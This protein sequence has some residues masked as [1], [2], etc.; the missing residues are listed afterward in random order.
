MNNNFYTLL[1][2]YIND[3]THFIF[4]KPTHPHLESYIQNNKSLN[5]TF[6]DLNFDSASDIIIFTDLLKQFEKSVLYIANPTFPTHCKWNLSSLTQMSND[7]P[8]TTFIIDEQFMIDN[9][10]TNVVASNIIVIPSK[11]INNIDLSTKFNEAVSLLSSYNIVVCNKSFSPTILVSLGNKYQWLLSS[12]IPHMPTL[13]GIPLNDVQSFIDYIIPL[14]THV[15]LYPPI[16]LHYINKVHQYHVMTILK[17]T[18]EILNR[19]NFPYWAESGTL[20]G[21]ARNN[22]II[23]WDD[24][25]DLSILDSDVS[26]LLSLQSEFNNNNLRIVPNRINTY[27]KVYYNFQCDSLQ[28]FYSSDAYHA[29]HID[30]FNNIYDGKLLKYYDTRFHVNPVFSEVNKLSGTVSMYCT[31]DDVF[32][33]QKSTINGLSI[34]IPSHT[35]NILKNNVGNNYKTNII[36]R[37]GCPFN[38]PKTYKYAKIIDGNGTHYIHS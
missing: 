4:T 38:N 10:H 22:Q 28:N 25:A 12:I 19:H 9:N 27:Y 5:Y 36:V 1:N 13:Y 30:I 14:I 3:E 29:P 17:H 35:D 34:N 16:Q 37:V 31:Y 2:S 32:P 8:S 21:I 18:L 26:L 15:D 7:H 20:L 33:L 11:I 23:P 24:D 6:I